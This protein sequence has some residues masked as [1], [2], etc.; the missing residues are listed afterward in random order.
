MATALN[1]GQRR[2][3]QTMMSQGILE[4]SVTR[5]L[6]KHCCEIHKV[7]YRHDQLDEFIKN[8]NTHLQPLFMEIRKGMSEDD[9]Q[10]YYALINLAETEITGMAC[11]YTE[12]ELELF[13]K[14][15]DLVLESESGIASSTDI[16]N[17]A[18]QLQP[19]KMKKKEA[20]QVLQRYVQDKWLCEAK[21]EYILSTRCIMEL[22][23][24]IRNMYQDLVKE[25]NICHNI[26]IQ[27][28]TCELCAARI[29]LPCA[30]KYFQGRDD[31]C[32][33]HC[34]EFWPHEIPAVHRTEPSMPPPSSTPKT[35]HRHR[36]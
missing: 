13:K 2:F 11:D 36:E 15:L 4:G 34:R 9:G 28:Q 24:Y 6:H 35:R 1:D 33:P 25:C 7:H 32:C 10:Q 20:E 31:P 30:A 23:Q 19:K 22:E 29:H 12:T 16:L 26:A 18:D 27:G 3:L 14:T 5:K 17:L 21:G 8:I